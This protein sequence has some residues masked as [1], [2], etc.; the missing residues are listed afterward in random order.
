MITSTA[1]P[2]FSGTADTG[3]SVQL[4]V[5][6]TAQGS[7][8]ANNSGWWSLQASTLVDGFHNATLIATDGAGNHASTSV[9]FVIGEF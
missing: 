2:T 1:A 5:D 3:A 6:G 8:V 7:T 4:L 9:T